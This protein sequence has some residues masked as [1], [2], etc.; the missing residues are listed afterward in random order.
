MSV[1]LFRSQYKKYM[2]PAGLVSLRC[3][4]YRFNVKSSYFIYRNRFDNVFV[5]V[6]SF[7]VC[8]PFAQRL[9]E[10][11]NV[12][13]ENLRFLFQEL[14]EPHRYYDETPV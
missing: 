10:E 8:N 13:E 5:C 2:F 14:L 3:L 11:G 6:I 1:T 7:S 9:V 12:S 4:G